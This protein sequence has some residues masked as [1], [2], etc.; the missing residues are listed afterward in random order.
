MPNTIFILSYVST[1][2][3]MDDESILGNA[4]PFLTM[5]AAKKEVQNY[6]NDLGLNKD[7]TKDYEELLP[8]EDRAI[9]LW[10]E[11]EW[12]KAT[13]IINCESVEIFDHIFLIREFALLGGPV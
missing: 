11:S 4:A 1:D 12:Y 8:E 9:I 10:I 5:E 13:N 3:G 2:N 6:L 7:P